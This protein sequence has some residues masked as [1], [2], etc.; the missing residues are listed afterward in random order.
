MVAVDIER[1]IL[2]L[3]IRQ[4][5]RDGAIQFFTYKI[6]GSVCSAKHIQVEIVSLNTSEIIKRIL[7]T[8]ILLF[9]FSQ[10][11]NTSFKGIT[12]WPLSQVYILYCPLAPPY[13]RASKE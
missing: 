11:L 3:Q 9:A 8:E 10:L 6:I 13:V 2:V 4:V 5:K 7:I 12:I 1:V